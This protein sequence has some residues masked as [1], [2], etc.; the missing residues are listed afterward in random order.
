MLS[1]RAAGLR[2]RA[3]RRFSPTITASL[4]TVATVVL[5]AGCSDVHTVAPANPTQTGVAQAALRICTTGDYKPL[6]FRDPT[7]GQYS[8]ID[9]DM[10]K[11]LAA[12]LGRTP[13]F[14]PTTWVTL[15]KDIATPG[16]C[17]IAMGGISPTP[18][19]EQAADF[20]P[21]YLANG[22]TPLTT[23]ANADRFQTVD[24]INQHGV[25]VIEPAGGTN[26]QFAKQSLPNATLIV[27]QDNTAVFGQLVAGTA[28]V[29]VT[30]AIEAIYQSKQH[31][32]LVAV[33]PD[34]SFTTDH[35]AY[36]LPKGSQLSQQTTEWLNQVL[37]DGTFTRIYNQWMG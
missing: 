13:T 35:K 28:D 26:E 21:P 23:A 7:T 24:Q 31:P 9:I 32:E 33:H 15:M 3:H 5:G 34:K 8:G 20:A 27:D 37:S 18:A 30:D 17:D 29:M 14:V 12:H 25:R 2:N 11:D 1:E 36:M 19:R 10:A 4:L 16:K 22:K 6:T